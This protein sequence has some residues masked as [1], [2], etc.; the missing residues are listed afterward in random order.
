MIEKM[1]PISASNLPKSN[2]NFSIDWLVKSDKNTTTTSS[3]TAL[4]VNNV[5]FSESTTKKSAEPLTKDYER[6][7]STA[8]RLQSSPVSDDSDAKS[9]VRAQSVSPKS[10]SIS[11][12]D[13]QSNRG[14]PMPNH[15]AHPTPFMP[16]APSQMP[17]HPIGPHVDA[18]QHQQ[19][20]N[21]QLQMA[22]LNYQRQATAHPQA[23]NFSQIFSDNFHRTSYQMQPWL[24]SRQH[25]FPYGFTGGKFSKE[26]RLFENSKPRRKTLF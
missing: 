3:P 7:I 6:E 22:A 12:F 26:N 24:F 11:F 14:A 19:F 17:T 4:P 25:R 23:M 16:A 10:D 18:L 15:F 2:S 9:D 8:L 21:A 20:I 1:T 13:A 5:K